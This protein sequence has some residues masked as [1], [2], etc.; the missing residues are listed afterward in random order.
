[1]IIFNEIISRKSFIFKCEYKR[2]TN[3]FLQKKR[4]FLYAATHFQF[5]QILNS[6]IYASFVARPPSTYITNNLFIHD[7]F[8]PLNRTLTIKK[9]YSL[10]LKLIFIFQ[11]KKLR[12]FPTFENIYRLNQ[13][14]NKSIATRKLCIYSKSR[15]VT[16][17]TKLLLH[18]EVVSVVV[19]SPLPSQYVFQYVYECMREYV[20]Y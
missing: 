6:S 1:M 17:K 9:I 10:D 20:V 5:H 13:L 19:M 2:A 18:F 14:I 16:S 15:K 3:L 7:I 12:E 4:R 11:D 8:F